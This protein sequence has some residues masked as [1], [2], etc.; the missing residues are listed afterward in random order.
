MQKYWALLFGAMILAEAG[1]FLVAPF[2]PG[3]WLPHNLCSFGPKTDGLFYAILAVTG[4]FFLLT[5]GIM[6]YALWKYVARPGE[7]STYTHGSHKL[8]LAW[9]I[10]PALI[11]LFIAFAQVKA[12]SDIK[13]SG[14]DAAAGPG[15]RADGPPVRVALPLSHSG[16]ERGDGRGLEGR[17]G[18]G[19]RRRLAARAARRRCPYR[20]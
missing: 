8:E 10:V 7:K 18:N 3:W 2:V 16:P 14:A 15:V 6:V 4:F 1:L 5:E 9:T 12:W 19:G 11:L 17:P 13:Y 20:Q